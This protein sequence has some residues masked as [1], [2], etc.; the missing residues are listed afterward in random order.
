MMTRAC[1]VAK[2]SHPARMGAPYLTQQLAS[3]P[4]RNG[5][6]RALVFTMSKPYQFDWYAVFAG[7][8]KKQLQIRH[9]LPK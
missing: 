2:K 7:V 5:R 1:A 4:M 9:D 3:L 8:G 6:A